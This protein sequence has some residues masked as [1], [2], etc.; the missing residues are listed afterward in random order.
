MTVSN[1]IA[2]GLSGVG[3]TVLIDLWALFLRSAFQI[4]SLNLCLLGRWVLHMPGGTFAHPN[5]A[6]AAAKPGECAIGWATHYSIGIGL[7]GAFSLL[8]G[9]EWWKSPTLWQPLAFGI[10]SVV[11]P[12]FIMQPALG[13]GMA[14]SRTPNPAAARLKSLGTHSMF[15]LGLYLSARLIGL[16]LPGLVGA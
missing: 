8:A 15:G 5:I 1:L 9:T 14:S 7:G 3:A 6:K 2:G 16:L 4:P 12:F 13:L 11:M 10:V